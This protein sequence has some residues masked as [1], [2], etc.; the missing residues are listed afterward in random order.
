MP[1]QQRPHA[2]ADLVE[3]VIPAAPGLKEHG[4]SVEV[5]EQD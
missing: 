2:S 4:F 1:E 3:P 5:P